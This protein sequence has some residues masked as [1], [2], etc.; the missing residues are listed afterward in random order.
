[1][2]GMVLEKLLVSEL[3]KVAGNVERKIV[4]CGITK[5][6]CECSEL[7]SGVYQKYWSKLLEVS[8]ID[9]QNC[10]FVINRFNIGF[11]HVF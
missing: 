6:L 8:K 10:V 4:A 11:N 5:L 1:M 2:F 9:C 7:Y 3:Q